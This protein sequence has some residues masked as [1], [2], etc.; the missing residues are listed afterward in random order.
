MVACDDSF[1]GHMLKLLA[2]AIAD[3]VN[4]IFQNSFAQYKLPS[5][6]KF[7]IVQSIY[8][9]KTNRLWHHPTDLLDCDLLLICFATVVIMQYIIRSV[10]SNMVS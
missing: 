1:P 10:A 4:T 6:W 7:V 8:K 9:E 3:P 2:S 5:V